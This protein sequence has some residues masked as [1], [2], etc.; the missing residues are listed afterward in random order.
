MSNVALVNCVGGYPDPSGSAEVISCLNLVHGS[1]IFELKI[2]RRYLNTFAVSLLNRSLFDHKMLTF[3]CT[4][5]LRE[6]TQYLL[7]HH[8]IWNK[9]QSIIIM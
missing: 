6:L 7:I 3:L 5:L 8:A 1:A 2:D 4:M 9:E